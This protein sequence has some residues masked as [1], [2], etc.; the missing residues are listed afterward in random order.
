VPSRSRP[1]DTRPTSTNRFAAQRLANTLG[2]L[3]SAYG[4][5]ASAATNPAVATR[6]WRDARVS[7]TKSVEI[8][9]ADERKS[10]LSQVNKDELTATL[11]LATKSDRELARLA[12][13]SRR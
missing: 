13:R 10:A 12:D 2:T 9:G 3:A 7:A 5:M 1:L 6:L 11:A 8:L 4:D